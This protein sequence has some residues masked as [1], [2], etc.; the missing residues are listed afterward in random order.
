MRRRISWRGRRR[1]MRSQMTSAM[2]PIGRLTQKKCWEGSWWEMKPT[3]RRRAR[4]SAGKAAAGEDAAD[5]A[6]V[7]AALAW[8]DEVGDGGV[9]QADEAAAAQAL[10]HAEGD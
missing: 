9:G 7:A 10:Q 3:P 1:R 6:L 5:I 8:A 2:R 4:A